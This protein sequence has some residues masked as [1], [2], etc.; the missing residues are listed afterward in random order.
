MTLLTIALRGASRA[1]VLASLG[2]AVSL[3]F[4]A[5]GAA[6]PVNAALQV[7]D[8]ETVEVEFLPAAS[9]DESTV[10]VHAAAASFTIELRR[11]SV[12]SKSFQILVQNADGQLVP[13]AAPP[14]A[15]YRGVV[16]EEPGSVVAA[17]IEDEG[18]TATITLASG[19]TLGVQPLREILPDA[20][21]S[22]H[23][24]YDAASIEHGEFVCGVLGAPREVSR[25]ARNG[26][27]EP[28]GLCRVAEIAID[29]DVEFFESEGSV[30][31]AIGEIESIINGVNVIYERD[32]EIT[33]RISSIFIRPTEP[34]PYSMTNP[35]ESLNEFRTEWS[36][37]HPDI[38]RDV[39]HLFTGR[40]LE[41]RV[42]GIAYLGVI[43][44]E[45]FGYA[46]SQVT[47]TTN[48]VDEVALVAHELGHNWNAGHCSST[49]SSG[50]DCR[51]MCPCLG[52]C[53]EDPT[54]FGAQSIASI[55]SFARSRPCLDDDECEPGVR[56][57]GP[58]PGRAGFNNL[59]TISNAT[60][61]GEV[62]I[63]WALREG[64][65]N[66]SSCAGVQ[67]DLDDANVAGEVVASVSGIASFTG[68]VPRGARGRALLIQA[69]DLASCRL[70]NS[71]VYQFP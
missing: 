55:S 5:N 20:A 45:S 41:G 43:C 59:V 32:V 15:V 29:S 1:P 21:P 47:F 67:L 30:T 53:A 49:C 58:T 54:R 13:V 65:T 60:A 22:A 2:L 44:T 40:D 50:S 9:A 71:V 39:A 24:L 19:V 10:I 4:A 31:A 3:G 18:I 27:G 69:V 8:S 46:V 70:S 23:I 28:D 6:N 25:S 57:S 62:R 52:G 14:S 48:H 42:I 35:S 34:D 51:I 11:V 36:G 38:T 16:F 26:A 66:V 33:H 61:N 17:S 56:L 68:F 7:R 37:N 64:R 12:R 63:Y